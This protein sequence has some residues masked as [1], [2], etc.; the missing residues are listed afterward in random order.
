M[1]EQRWVD[2]TTFYDPENPKSGNC[3]QAAVASILGVNLESVPDFKK[4]AGED[5]YSFWT[6]FE[7]FLFNQ[8]FWTMRKDGP[9]YIPEGYYLACGPSSRDC[10]HM[11]VMR[12]GEL[13]HDPHPSKEGIIEVEHIWMLIPMDPAQHPN[14]GKA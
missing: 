5:A 9:N 8:G 14:R 7:D 2:Q 6:L 12:S 10:G 11:V 1:K 4:E 13:A 3:A